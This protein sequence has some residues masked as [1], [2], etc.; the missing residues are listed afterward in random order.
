MARAAFKRGLSINQTKPSMGREDTPKLTDLVE[1]YDWPKN[2]ASGTVRATGPVQGR[3]LHKINV[4]KK[5]GSTTE[6]T[7]VCLA[8][9]VDTDE[10]D[11]DVECPYCNLP[12]GY[13]T[14]K[15]RYFLN[16]IDRRIEEDAPAKIKKTAEELKTGFKD[17]SSNSWTPARVLG[18]PSSVATRLQQ[19][20]EKN[21]VKS[22]SGEKKAFD[23]NHD[24]FGFDMDISF[25]KK[26]AAANMYSCD[27]NTEE[28]FTPLG[29]EQLEY[30]LWDLDK[31]YEPEELEQARREAKSLQDRWRKHVGDDDADDDEDVDRH[32]RGKQGAK[33]GKGKPAP[34][35]S[36][37]EESYDDDDG[38]S[39]DGE[40]L[41]L[42]SE[43]EEDEYADDPPPRRG[44]AKKAA[45]KRRQSEPEED[46]FDDGE[47]GEDEY[48][49]EDGEEESEDDDFDKPAPKRGAAKKPTAKKPSRR[50]EP[51]PE[52]D[53][54]DDGEEGDDEYGEE[55][56]PTPPPRRK[57]A[58][59][60]GGKPQGKPSGKPSPKRKP[61]DEDLD[62]LDDMDDDIPF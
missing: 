30:L 40:E 38:E 54:F 34:K 57:P 51:E 25:D 55:E 32:P 42:E 43:E 13:Q 19:L 41:D 4:A 35:R 45:P 61:A 7:K 14:R 23:F 50:S 3:G 31:I 48:G 47:E 26:A 28:R 39:D 46:E 56:E 16:V 21:V 44:A 36:K 24:R 37:Q 2:G 60:R 18:I 59:A 52:E 9:N 58:P 49:E 22:K 33:G 11:H 5:D 17:M 1:M 10:F 20:S 29:E 53:E 6:I 12:E 62:D 8:Y 27:R 15:K